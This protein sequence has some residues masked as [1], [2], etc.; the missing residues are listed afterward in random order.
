MTEEAT[1]QLPRVS[2]ERRAGQCGRAAGGAGRCVI[3]PRAGGRPLRTGG[4]TDIGWGWAGAWPRHSAPCG[5]CTRTAGGQGGE[6]FSQGRGHWREPAHG[7]GQARRRPRGR[8]RAALGTCTRTAGM[9][10]ACVCVCARGRGHASGAVWWLAG[11]S[12][13]TGPLT[14][15]PGWYEPAAAAACMPGGMLH[16]LPPPGR[17]FP[18]LPLREESPGWGGMALGATPDLAGQAG[19]GCRL[20]EPSGPA[21]CS[22]LSDLKTSLR[23]HG[24]QGRGTPCSQCLPP[25]APGASS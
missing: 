23:W 6:K 12:V 25:W 2:Q 7:R 22:V 18:P 17:W 1:A 24:P 8:R 5:S 19:C 3:S 9:G 4:S 15:L 11:S 14:P 13:M 21:A 20:G 16:A 10:C